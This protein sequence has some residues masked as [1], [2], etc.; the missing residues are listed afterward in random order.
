MGLVPAGPC[1]VTTAWLAVPVTFSVTVTVRLL[2]AL[3]PAL[4]VSGSSDMLVIAGCGAAG[5]V[6]KLRMLPR[7]VPALF[8]ATTR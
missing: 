8:V 4:T 6:V 7:V 3:L 1:K 5:C 2:V